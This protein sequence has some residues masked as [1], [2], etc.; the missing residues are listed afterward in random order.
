MV[1]LKET[2]AAG[3]RLQ[4]MLSCMLLRRSYVPDGQGQHARLQTHELGIG[5]VHVQSSKSKSCAALT[6]AS[7]CLRISD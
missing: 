2:G 7:S 5:E 6:P 3:L 4:L 1:C